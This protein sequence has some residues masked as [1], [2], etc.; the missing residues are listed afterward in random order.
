MSNENV[1]DY[2]LQFYNERIQNTEYKADIIFSTAQNKR[3]EA[4]PKGR[5]ELK[6]S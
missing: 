6:G 2:R 5:G 4:L 3:K 1:T